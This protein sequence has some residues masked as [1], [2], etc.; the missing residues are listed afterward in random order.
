MSTI[1][2]LAVAQ[3]S[4]NLPSAF[5]SFQAVYTGE[6]YLVFYSAPAIVRLHLAEVQHSLVVTTGARIA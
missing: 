5:V 4:Q 3:Q 2:G 1:C 6:S